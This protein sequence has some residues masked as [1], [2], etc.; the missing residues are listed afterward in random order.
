MI[1]GPVFAPSFINNEWVFVHRTVGTFPRLISVP[2]HFY[3]VIVGKNAATSNESTFIAA[4]LVPNL[5]TVPKDVSTSSP[6]PPCTSLQHPLMLLCRYITGSSEQLSGAAG[7]ARSNSGL[8]AA[9]AL[10]HLCSEGAPRS[11]RAPVQVR[12][13][14]LYTSIYRYLMRFWL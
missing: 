10:P 6:R 11:L 7:P 1:T 4:F 14:M 13:S 8:L 2:T 12:R 9:A 3:K 5:N